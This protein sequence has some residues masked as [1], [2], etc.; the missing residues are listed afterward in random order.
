M[1]RGVRVEV[2]VEEDVFGG[3]DGAIVVDLNTAEGID[4]SGLNTAMSAFPSEP[5]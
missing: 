2:F 5:C 1:F 4:T 3:G